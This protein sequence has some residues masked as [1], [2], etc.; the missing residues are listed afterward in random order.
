[1]ANKTNS[2]SM[3]G[4]AALISGKYLEMRS[5]V[6]AYI[7]KRTGS[8]EDSE[9]LMQETFTRLLEYR[10]VLTGHTLDRF[11]YRTAHNL[12]VDWYRR[13][14]LSEKAQEYFA[15]R[16]KSADTS[17]EDIRLK[18]MMRTEQ[19]CVRKMGRRKGALS[20]PLQAMQGQIPGVIIT[21]Q[22][23]A[24]GDEN[25]GMSLRGAVSTNSSEPLVIID[26]VAYE[27]INDMRLLNPSDI[28]SMS[29]L[30]DGAAAIYGSRAAGGVV[31]ITTKKGKEGRAKVEYSGSYTLKTV[32][33]MP[34]L[35]TLDEWSDAIMTTLADDTGNN[36]YR[37]AQLA[38]QYKGQYIDLDETISPSGT[39]GFTDVADFVFDDSVDWLG[40]LFGNAHSTTQGGISAVSGDISI[41]CDGPATAAVTVSGEEIRYMSDRPCTVRAG[42]K[43]YRLPAS[44]FQKIMIRE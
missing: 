11:I 21:R 9:D 30:K 10:T 39:T 42:K 12:V 36:W 33:R 19:V 2:D 34:E 5:A 32:G 18:E 3:S 29:F 43:K 44:D 6:F 4:Q 31:L 22:S 28:E 24:P 20:S 1:M 26:G 17:E 15:S 27:S 23:S 41:K 7:L 25:W 16:Q 37:Y 14:A 8:V 38:Q 13:H 35:M 40:S